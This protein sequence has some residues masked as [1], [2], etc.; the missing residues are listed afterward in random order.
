[1]Y[2][3][4]GIGKESGTRVVMYIMLSFEKAF[5]ICEC[6]GWEWTDGAGKHWEMEIVEQ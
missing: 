4:I 1:M 6:C 5:E 2:K 3:I